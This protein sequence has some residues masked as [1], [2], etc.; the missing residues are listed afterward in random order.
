MVESKEPTWRVLSEV[1]GRV[2][3][4]L[5]V[6][7]QVEMSKSKWSQVGRDAA[8]ESGWPRRRPSER[9]AHPACDRHVRKRLHVT[10]FCVGKPQRWMRLPPLVQ[11]K[12]VRSGNTTIGEAN[13]MFPRHI[14]SVQWEQA[15]GYA[16]QACARIFR[17]GGSPADGAQGVRLD[18]RR[19]RR[20]EH[21]GRSHCPGFVCAAAAQGCIDAR[22]RRAVNSEA[23]CTVSRRR[24]AQYG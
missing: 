22:A 5:P 4:S 24:S 16:R 17:D 23:Y 21:R 1:V 2:L 11:H 14:N 3:S 9:Q 10:R 6:P 20:L 18:R 8:S 19:Q 7:A 12:C 15:L 13:R